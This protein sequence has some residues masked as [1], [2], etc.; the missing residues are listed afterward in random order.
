MTATTDSSTHDTIAPV[1]QRLREMLAIESTIETQLA[2]GQEEVAGHAAGAAFERLA[3]TARRQQHALREIENELGGPP[4]PVT[5]P[6]DGANRRTDEP[7]SAGAEAALRGVA[8]ALHDAVLGYAALHQTAH[9]F[10]T[11][12][13]GGVLKLAAQHLR[14][15][16]AAA[17]E[18]DHLISDVVAW[19]LRR[20]GQRCVCPCPYCSLGVCWCIADTTDTLSGA[21]RDAAP[22]VDGVRVAR[23]TRATP[24]LAIAEGDVVIAVNATPVASL[25]DVRAAAPSPPPGTTVRLTVRHMDGATEEVVAARA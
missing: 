11:G 5:D 22:P 24:D 1:R 8:T 14:T 20:D 15:Y 6:P 4:T 13:L 9:V 12:Q 18:M 23:N 25:A 19:E 3:E 2:A 21:W 7:A 10:H 17:S 16:A